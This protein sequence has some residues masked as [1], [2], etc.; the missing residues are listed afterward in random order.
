MKISF[1]WLLE[2][3][4][5]KTII[6]IIIIS[7][8]NIQTSVDLKTEEQKLNTKLSISFIVIHILQIY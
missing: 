3:D 4:K 1:F 8:T 2:L 5:L 6:K 7:T